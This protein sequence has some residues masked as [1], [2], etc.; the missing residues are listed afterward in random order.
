MRDGGIVLALD[1]SHIKG[2]VA[3]SKGGELLRSILFDASDTHSATLMPA[4]DSCLSGSGVGIGE[5]DRFAVVS[6]PGSFTGLRIGL[7]TI[8]AF[9][10]IGRR[11]VSA[12]KSLELLAAAMPFAASPVAT[13][14]DAR[15]SEVYAAVYD[16]SSGKPAELLAPCAL[17]PEKTAEKLA[18]EGLHGPVIFCGTGA[19]RYRDTIEGLAG[20][21]SVF[22]GPLHAQPSAAALAAL[23]YE[24]EP[25]PYG[26]LSSLEPF[27]LRPPDA[28]LPAGARLLSGG[29]KD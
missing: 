25:V 12:M 1:T 4:V 7:A 10:S 14:I 13:L 6:G 19:I 21:G 24:L 27:Y 9:A 29:G 11:P 23:A 17:R 16:T 3:V 26:E 8:K 18:E 20:D 15:R 5:V 2:S 28:K 22:A